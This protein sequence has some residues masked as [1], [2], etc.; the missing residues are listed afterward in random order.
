MVIKE[1]ALS[2]DGYIIN[3]NNIDNIKY[4]NTTSDYNGCG[5]AACYNLCKYLKKDKSVEDVVAFLE[6]YLWCKGSLGTA[7]NGI[8]KFMK[9]L[10]LNVKTVVGKPAIVKAKPEF[11]I[12]FYFYGQGC[13]Y[14]FFYKYDNTKYRFLND[15]LKEYDIR[16]LSKMLDDEVKCGACTA[17]I[18]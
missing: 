8:Y 6:K 14:T 2:R 13:H 11:G 5:W 9:A 15:S 17:F 10:G 7:L 12:V 16:T 3:Q 18:V 1:S 4:G